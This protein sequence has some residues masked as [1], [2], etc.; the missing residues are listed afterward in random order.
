MIT[1]QER[2]SKEITNGLDSQGLQTLKVTAREYQI[3]VFDTFKGTKDALSR[4]LTQ[5]KSIR[6]KHIE[7]GTCK[8]DQ[9]NHVNKSSTTEKNTETENR[10]KQWLKRKSVNQKIKPK[11]LCTMQQKNIHIPL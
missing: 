10:K 2:V 7:N 1:H 3:A 6:Y 8:A 9:Y 4:M 11:S 5:Q